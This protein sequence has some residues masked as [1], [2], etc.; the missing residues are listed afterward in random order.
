MIKLFDYGN[1]E[2]E[3]TGTGLLACDISSLG[4]LKGAVLFRKGYKKTIT[5]GNAEFD[6]AAYLID[7][8][9]LE[10]L[11]LKDLYDFAQ[12]TP[13]NEQNTSSLGIIQEVRS[14]KPQFDLMFAKG[15]CFHKA[16]YN[17]RGQGRWDFGLVFES[18]I[19]MATNADKTELKGFDGGMFSVETFKLLQGTD[20]EMSTAK[21]QLLNAV[22]FNERSVRI[23]FEKAGD[24]GAVN[25]VIETKLTL[26][27]ITAGTTATASI[28]SS[29]N[30][31]DSVLDLDD[32]GNFVLLGEQTS[33][34][35]ISAV[36]YNVSTN[37]YTFTF[38][39]PLVA[40]DTVQI[41]LGDGTY[42]VIEDTIGNL[43]KGT[44]NLVTVS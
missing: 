7:V 25:G 22:E 21:I 18:V 3:T 34:T 32:V 44:S 36:S 8:K 5:D 17:K 42:D 2:E 26:D 43:Y 27:P 11:P 28:T 23:P 20:L 41:K 16:L 4:D 9:K 13:E 29:C 35:T 40:T 31:G 6:L 15:S 10:A 12:N 30:T 37:K 19:L 39:T 14:G 1:C 33:A 38:D 24:I